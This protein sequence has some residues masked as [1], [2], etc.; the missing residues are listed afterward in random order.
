MLGSKIFN[1]IETADYCVMC[2]ELFLKTSNHKGLM[3]ITEI[4]WSE[5][6][7]TLSSVKDCESLLNVPSGLLI[8]LEELRRHM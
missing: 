7:G 8:S 3:E 4:H 1:Q 2:M 6:V 5:N